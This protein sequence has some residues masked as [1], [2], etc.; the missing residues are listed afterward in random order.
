MTRGSD[1]VRIKEIGTIRIGHAFR[2]RLL[3]RPKGNALV[4]QPKNILS[5][6]FISFA[7]NEPLRTVA[8]A[9][10]PLDEDDVLIVNRGRFAATVFTLSGPDTWIVPSSILILTVT[11]PTVLPAYV[12]SYFNSAAGQ[13]MFQ[14]H[15]EQTTVSFISTSNLGS[16]EIPIPPRERQRSLIALDRVMAE[17]RNLTDK[18]RG[19]LRQIINAELAADSFT[20]NRE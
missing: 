20:N 14:A 13:K 5:D 10:K 16:M 1:I 15:S 17:H 3:S 11:A 4:I 2:G 7:Q 18:K 9:V 6:G 12:S 8:S 19:L